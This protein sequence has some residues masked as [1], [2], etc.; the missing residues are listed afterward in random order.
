MNETVDQKSKKSAEVKSFLYK[1]LNAM[2]F[3]IFGTIVVG[4]IIQ[5]LGVVT[6]IAALGRLSAILTSLLGMG[7]GLSIGLALKVDGLK[8]VMLSVAGGIATQFGVDFSMEGWLNPTKVPNNPV[9]AYLVVVAVYFVIKYVFRKKTA[10]DLFFIPLVTSLSALFAVYLFSW[11]IDKLMEA[12]YA[13]IKFFMTSEPYLTSAFV[14]LIFGILLTLPFISSAGVAIAV[15]TVPFKANDPIA[16]I[17]M[18]AAVVGCTAQMVGFAIQSTRKNDIGTIFTIGVASSMFQFK[19]V[20]KK[21]ITWV[22]TLIASFV[23]PP[24]CYLLFGGYGWFI[25]GIPAGHSFTAAWPGMG[26]SGIVGQLQ[27]LTIGNFSVEA[28]L[29]VAAQVLLPAVLVFGLDTL[30]IKLKWYESTDLIL[31]ASL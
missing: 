20:M 8:L 17:A 19:N 12:I 25:N 4:A 27:V 11:P 14:G 2:T 18:C 29:F 1:S 28:W 30:F 24:L 26:S 7:I 16:I 23:L 22:P 6:G 31:D 5:T 10:Y 3:G 15:F 9:T 13:T 21:L